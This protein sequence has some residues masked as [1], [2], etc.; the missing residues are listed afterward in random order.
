[1]NLRRGKLRDPLCPTVYAFLYASPCLTPSLLQQTSFVVAHPYPRLPFL[2]DMPPKKKKER[3]RKRGREREGDRASERERERE[4]ASQPEEER[5]KVGRHV[6]SS[7]LLSSCLSLS[8]EKLIGNIRFSKIVGGLCL[9][10]VFWE[11]LFVK[12]LGGLLRFAFWV[13]I[14][15]KILRGRCLRFVFWEHTFSKILGGR[16]LRIVC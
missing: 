15:S 13:H 1:M 14:F 8:Q 16:C 6:N 10:S 11:L 5:N 9:R 2:Q 3:E 12:T 4:Q 7:S